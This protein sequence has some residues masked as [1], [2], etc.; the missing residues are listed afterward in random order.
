MDNAGNVAA[1]AHQPDSHDSWDS[2]YQGVQVCELQSGGY[3]CC[4]RAGTTGVHSS[5]MQIIQLGWH[6]RSATCDGSAAI[7]SEAGVSLGVLQASLVVHSR[8]VGNSWGCIPGMQMTRGCAGQVSN[9]LCTVSHTGQLQEW[10][11]S[12][13]KGF[14]SADQGR[15]VRCL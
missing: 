1:L 10:K 4:V 12:R 14:T 7:G 11:D 6:H 9:L 13:P 3:K 15:S 5:G 2:Y 8:H